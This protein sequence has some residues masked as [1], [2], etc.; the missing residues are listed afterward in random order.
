M[1]V[2]LGFTLLLLGMWF[3]LRARGLQQRAGLPTGRVV[4]M[5]MDTAHTLARPLYDPH[6]GLVGKPDYILEQG[7]A[8]IPV[9]VKTGHTPQQPYPGHVYQLAAYGLLIQRV[10]G[11]PAPYGFLRYPQATFR[12][13]F[14]PRLMDELLAVLAA[15][16]ADEERE[17]VPRSHNHPARCRACGFREICNQ[18]LA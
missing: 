1:L 3:L 13:E 15:L 16:R 11:R 8:L 18:R 17:D 7:E 6:I 4:Y 5:D 14:T 9:E 12:I 10:L 2:W